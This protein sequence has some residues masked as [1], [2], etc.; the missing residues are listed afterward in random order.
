MT[1]HL[2]NAK[3]TTFIEAGTQLFRV[4]PGTTRSSMI[5]QLLRNAMAKQ[6]RFSA[7]TAWLGATRWFFASIPCHQTRRSECAVGWGIWTDIRAPSVAG[8]AMQNARK[9]LHFVGGFHLAGVS[10][11]D[12]KFNG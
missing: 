6:L 11:R 8:K 7:P 10:C 1:L 9:I 4:S 3:G 5:S 12:G 2:S